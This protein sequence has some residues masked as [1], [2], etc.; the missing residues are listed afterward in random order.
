MIWENPLSIIEKTDFRFE[1][2][3]KIPNLES[4]M[5]NLK[6]PAL[7]FIG[8]VNLKSKNLK[9]KAKSILGGF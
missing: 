4:K 1:M 6:S 8:V 7:G 2:E 3:S 9:S 5:K